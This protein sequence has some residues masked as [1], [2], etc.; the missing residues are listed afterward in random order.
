MPGEVVKLPKD[1]YKCFRVHSVLRGSN[2]YL[3]SISL[4]LEKNGIY[5]YRDLEQISESEFWKI[6][7]RTTENNKSRM[8]EILEYLPPNFQVT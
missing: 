2:P 6:V 7:G 1:I 8:R 5:Y 3:H 4:K